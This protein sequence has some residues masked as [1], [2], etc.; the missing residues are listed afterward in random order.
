MYMYVRGIEFVSVT[1][2]FRLYFGFLLTEVIFVLCFITIARRIYRTDNCIGGVMA[3][4]LAP[5][6]VDSEVEPRSGQ[7]IDCK[8]HCGCFS[9]TKPV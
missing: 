2:M 8:L 6:E 4:M 9:A 5:S 1:T 7:T 3:T